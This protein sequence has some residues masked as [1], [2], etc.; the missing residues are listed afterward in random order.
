MAVPRAFQALRDFRGLKEILKYL[1]F[2]KKKRKIKE[3]Y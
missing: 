1:N 3:K 2:I